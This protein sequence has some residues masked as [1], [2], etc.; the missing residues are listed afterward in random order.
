VKEFQDILD[1]AVSLA[2]Q[3]GAKLAPDQEDT[4]KD[5]F[6]FE[7]RKVFDEFQRAIDDL[8][9]RIADMEDEMADGRPW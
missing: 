7:L 9:L 3:R 8:G 1:D 6:A 2:A 4:V 5:A